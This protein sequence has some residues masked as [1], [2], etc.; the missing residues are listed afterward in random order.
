MQPSAPAAA[1]ASAYA[2][3][4]DVVRPLSDLDLLLPSG[5]RGWSIADLTVHLSQDS[6]RALVTLAT[7]ADGPPD[8]DFTSYWR[9]FPGDDLEAGLAHAQWVRRTAA[10]FDRPSG[11]V[12]QWTELAEAAV[13][14][15]AAADPASTVSTQGHVL[16]VADFL[17]TLVTEAVIH[18][19]DAVVSLPG[20][21]EPGS[22]TTAVA[23]STMDGLLGPP[24]LP[25]SWSTRE[26]LLKS[27]GRTPLSRAD[28]KVLGP[29][30][31]QFP[32]L[33]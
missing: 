5:C 18:H 6:Q 24:G 30:A 28:R 15:A 32:L 27:A 9:D 7:P 2:G 26:A 3:F 23:K 1:L 11:V 17:S 16:T 14:A 13:R 22:D 10:A 21:P 12:A 25:P 4:S 8:V 31:D 29:R 33:G 20:A 19:L